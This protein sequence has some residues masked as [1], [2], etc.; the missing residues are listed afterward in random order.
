MRLLKGLSVAEA[1]KVTG[2]S[3]KKV[4]CIVDKT[5]KSAIADVENNSKLSADDFHVEKVVVE[6]GPLIKRYWPRSRGMAR[7]IARR[8][9]HIRVVLSDKNNS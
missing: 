4:A 6:K 3:G 5:I 7:P 2:F 9:S 1:L 8:T